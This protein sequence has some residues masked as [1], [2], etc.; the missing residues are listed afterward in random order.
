MDY[1]GGGDGGE[2]DDDEDDDEYEDDDGGDDDDEYNGNADGDDDDEYDGNDIPRERRDRCQSICQL[3][4]GQKYL[5]MSKLSQ[6]M[7]KQDWH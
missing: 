2:G 5:E 1:N 7:D 3:V 6:L 4:W